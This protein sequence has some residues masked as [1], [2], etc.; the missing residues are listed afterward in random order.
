MAGMKRFGEYA[1]EMGYCTPADVLRAVSIQDDLEARG[2]P[3][4]LIGLVMV[5]YGII[6]NGQLLHILKILE[7]Q[8]VPSILAG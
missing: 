5:R 1:V 7:Q 3:R 8:H 2:F 4:M 6:D